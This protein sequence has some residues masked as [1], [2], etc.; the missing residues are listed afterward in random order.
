MGQIFVAMPAG[1]SLF[2]TANAMERLEILRDEV[3]EGWSSVI[4]DEDRFEQGGWLDREQLTY[5]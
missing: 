5:I 1:G 3:T 4:V 2:Q